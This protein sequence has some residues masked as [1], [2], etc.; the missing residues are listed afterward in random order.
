MLLPPVDGPESLEPTTRLIATT[1]TQWLDEE[2][3][4]L[5]V[6]KDLG[7]AAADVRTCTGL[8]AHIIKHIHHKQTNDLNCD[9]LA[10][11]PASAVGRG[12]RGWL[13]AAGTQHPAA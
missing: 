2:W 11:V 10:G 12:P 5:E 1:I 7:D 8:Q 13:R 4:P 3:T 9:V 6:H